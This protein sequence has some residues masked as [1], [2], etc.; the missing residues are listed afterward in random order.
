MPRRERVRSAPVRTAAKRR[1]RVA[2]AAH[3]SSRDAGAGSLAQARLAAIVA[4]SDDAIVSKT[5]DGIITSWN[6][7]AEQLF[8]YSAAEAIGKSI[9]MIIPT[10]RLGE[11]DDVLS[12]LRRGEKIDH[13]ET[14][15]QTKDGRLIDVSVT[16]SP[17]RDD[18]GAI[19]G[20]S[21]VARDIGERKR[22]EIERQALLEREQA[23][24]RQ[25]ERA[26]L[27]RDE[28]LATVSHELRSPLNA[29]LGW[30]HLL[31]TGSLD[32]ERTQR[33]IDA[34]TR[35]AFMQSQLVADILDIQSLTSG[36]A[37]LRIQ[38]IDLAL[39][40]EAALDTVRPV[41]AAKNIALIPVVDLA[42]TRLPADGDRIQQVV[43]NLL[44]NAVKFSPDGGRVKIIL[45]DSG[46]RV[47]ITVEDTGPGVRPDFLP[48]VFERFRQDIVVAGSRG[49]LGLGLAIVRHLVELHG[50]MVAARN[51]EGGGGAIF[52]V[53]L[54]RSP[55]I[56]IETVT[57][58]AKADLLETPPALNDVRVL[59]VDDEPEAR[60]VLTAVLAQYG[61]DVALAASAAE[62]LELFGRVR[63]HV[64]V[65]DISMPGRDGYALMREI[66]ALPDTDGG[67]TPAI[68]L[69]ASA[70]VEDR[71]RALRAG[72]QFHVPKPVDPAELAQAVASL[73]T[74][75]SS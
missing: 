15:R 48:Y 24:R 55:T 49:G 41:A 8:G 5:L 56:H 65:S 38:D 66:R 32:A 71:L 73:A 64:V 33:A 17:I 46:S 29:I 39:V 22:G 54:P 37:R 20:A 6:R 75:R 14:V 59:V 42:N 44:S 21:K 67:H 30:A 52:S 68:A 3:S 11:E 61:A 57:R 43:W 40:V 9:T 18:T 10:D 63:P 74:S 26:V 72:F 47:E 45:R 16:V 2:P 70:S 1:K 51:R 13:F 36:K 7:G 50:G 19:V 60:E 25:A 69:T 62:A 23:A 12:R 31:K 28:F 35:N 34:I 53:W 27:V 58:T 4:S